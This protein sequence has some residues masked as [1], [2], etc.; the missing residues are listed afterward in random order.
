MS[1]ALLALVVVFAGLLLFGCVTPGPGPTPTPIPT[2]TPVPRVALEAEV[3]S[4]PAPF[5]PAYA[6]GCW[7]PQGGLDV[8]SC[9][10]ESDGEVIYL[11]HGTED[12]GLPSVV[13]YETPGEHVL[14]ITAVDK[15]GTEAYKKLVFTVTGGAETGL[16]NE[17]GEVTLSVAGQEATFSFTDEE[18][19]EPI[20][21]L[22]VAFAMDNETK[23]ALLLAIDSS[24]KYPPQIVILEDESNAT[25]KQA[26]AAKGIS[27]AGSGGKIS[28]PLT[29]LAYRVTRRVTLRWLPEQVDE[30]LSQISVAQL[31]Y[32]ALDNAGLPIASY[33]KRNCLGSTT[34]TMTPDEAMANLKTEV[35]DRV[36]SNLFFF[37]QPEFFATL[38]RS[39][40]NPQSIAI[41]AMN[42]VLDASATFACRDAN[43][44][45][46]MTEACGMKFYACKYSTELRDWDWGFARVSV[47]GKDEF[48]VPLSTGSLELFSKANAG[49]GYSIPLEG[50]KAAVEVP[51]GG[52]VAQIKAPGFASQTKDV[53]V[54]EGETPVTATLGAVNIPTVPTPSPV[55]V[56]SPSPSPEA[57]AMVSVKIASYRCE[58]KYNPTGPAYTYSVFASGTASGTVPNTELFAASLVSSELSCGS[59]SSVGSTMCDRGGGPEATS[60]TYS[61]YYFDPADVRSRGYSVEFFVYA[62]PW[63]APYGTWGAAMIG[64]RAEDRVQVPCPQ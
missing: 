35:K 26:P 27:F 29:K 21:G 20:S 43:Q 5:S 61:S 50:G 59:W 40:P 11:R 18:T 2:P 32:R 39:I 44:R 22:S 28:I 48:G 54:G 13:T 19:G 58:K 12:P 49:L 24:E 53:Q 4:G 64:N 9:E 63:S 60:W 51:K 15:Q 62:E 7:D 31:A 45:V 56:P 3:T 6:F 17:A 36:K 42:T 47:D 1:K 55:I 8:A 33:M 38:G 57:A 25:V 10:L 30:T 23:Q 14:E 41:D 52:Y 46:V 37:A 16:T 34:K